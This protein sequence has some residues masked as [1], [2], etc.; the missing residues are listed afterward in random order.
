M[1]APTTTVL[2]ADIGNFWNFS[3]TADLLSRDFVQQSVLAIALLALLGGLLGP[4][5]VARQ[6]SFA[7]H[8]AA[9]LSFT[10]AAAALLAGVGVNIGGVIGAVFAAAVSG[11]LGRR[12][13]ERDSVIGAVMAFGLGLGVLFL[14]LYGRVG[15]GFALLAGQVASVGRTGLIAV[16]VTAAVVVVVYAIIYRPLMFAS[17]DPRV[18][19][20]SGVPV[21]LLSVVFAILVGLA[22]AQGVQI[23]G[24]L[25]V[26][27]LLITPAAAAVRLSAN[28]TV[29]VVLSVVF[30]GVSAIGGLILSLAPELPVSVMVTT[31]SF[32]IYLVCRVVGMRSRD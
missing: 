14:S 13:R 17:L 30:A 29:V 12:A 19:A 8:G 18:A 28:P 31:I 15:T 6:M 20:A 25:L 2:A 4:M 11:L 23:I 3:Q 21:R 5:I 26:M 16:A 22:A 10:G 27:S 7:V 32:A 1:I 24:A 9:E